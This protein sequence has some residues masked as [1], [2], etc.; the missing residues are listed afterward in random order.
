MKKTETLTLRSRCQNCQDLYDLGGTFS[1]SDWQE[2]CAEKNFSIAPI[3]ASIITS[4]SKFNATLTYDTALPT[5]THGFSNTGVA[6]TT[7]STARKTSSTDGFSATNSRSSTRRAGEGPAG[8]TITLSG[9][10]TGMSDIQPLTTTTGIPPLQNIPLAQGG[11]SGS[12][13]ARGDGEVLRLAGFVVMGACLFF[14]A[15]FV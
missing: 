7:T 15:V 5:K 14:G 11:N 13:R 1:L 6:A 2:N 10:P 8:E 4:W 9:N 3:P 12:G